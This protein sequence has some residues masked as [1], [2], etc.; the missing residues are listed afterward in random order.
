[1]VVLLTAPFGR[2]IDL[3]YQLPHVLG[4]GLVVLAL[5]AWDQYAFGRLHRVTQ[6][7]GPALLVWE[8][9]PNLY[10]YSERWLSFSRWL[11]IV[12]ADL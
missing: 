3:P 11:V 12:A 8:L 6:Y 4:P 9:V 1:M 2:L 5:A 10:M 7:V